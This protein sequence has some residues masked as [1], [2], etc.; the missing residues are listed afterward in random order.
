MYNQN[1]FFFRINLTYSNKRKIDRSYRLIEIKMIFEPYSVKTYSIRYEKEIIDSTNIM[2]DF[3]NLTFNTTHSFVR[4]N[5]VGNC[6]IATSI[7]F[8][9]KNKW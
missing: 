2:A 1:F 3:H 8:Y 4:Q 9:R 6:L 5:L 7:Y